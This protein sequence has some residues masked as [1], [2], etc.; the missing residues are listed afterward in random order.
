MHQYDADTCGKRGDQRSENIGK[1]INTHIRLIL[2]NVSGINI[3][4]D[5]ISYLDFDL[6]LL[7]FTETWCDYNIVY[8]YINP[9]Y[10]NR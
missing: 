3:K 7:N 4:K 5:L 1:I 2:L 9:D 6:S 10:Q 8:I